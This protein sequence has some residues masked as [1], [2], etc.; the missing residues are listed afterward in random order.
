MKKN[1]KGSK[2]RVPDSV[3]RVS[4]RTNISSLLIIWI[5]YSDDITL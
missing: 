4:G 3:T 5:K 1:N 2:M